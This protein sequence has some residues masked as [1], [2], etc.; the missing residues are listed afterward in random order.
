MHI[1]LMLILFPVLLAIKA[2]FNLAE[3]AL[4]TARVSILESSVTSKGVEKVLELKKEPGLFL[5]AIRAGDTVTDLFTGALVITSIEEYVRSSLHGVPVVGSYNSAVAS[6][7]GFVLITYV[8][9]VFADLAPKSIALSAPERLAMVVATP[10]RIFI[11]V[12]R[13]FFA[14]LEGSNRIVL[15]LLRVKAQREQRV[16]E[17]EIRHIL[18][19]ELSAGVPLF[20]GS[21]M[22]RV[23]DL[24]HRSVRTV[25]T[26]RPE[27]QFLQRDSSA[28]ALK[29]AV[30][31]ATAS[32]LL[33]TD[34]E[35]LDK[36]IGVVSRADVLAAIARDETF[37]LKALVTV[38]TYVADNATLLSV[39][40]K[41]KRVPTHMGLVVDEFGSLAGLVT[42][43]DVI[44]AVAGEVT[45]AVIGDVSINDVLGEFKE[46][47]LE[48]DSDGSYIVPGNQPVDDCVEARILPAPAARGY[49]TMAGLVLDSLRRI[50]REGEMIDLPTLRVEVVSVEHGTV[51]TL[52]L[53]PKG[54]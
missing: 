38:P 3:E 34:H 17:K 54:D 40:E 24:E 27:I 1:G 18:S 47:Q 46:E 14:F 26:G 28:D 36:P 23:L 39:L 31:E 13:P 7:V 5:A 53:I 49:K 22:E 37:D 45:E 50:P 41:L 52:R 15:N 6:F 21:M 12:A 10:L 44:E 42:L 33:V 16:T 11:V 9:L 35:N 29:A 8:T 2:F 32:L 48:K 4:V 19:N 25:M 51:K 20:E 30:L 43:T